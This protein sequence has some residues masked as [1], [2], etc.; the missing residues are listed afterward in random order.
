MRLLWSKPGHGK[1]FTGEMML[2]EDYKS[3]HPFRLPGAL[4]S[5]WQ[6]NLTLARSRTSPVTLRKPV[7]FW[8]R[9]QAEHDTA[10]GAANQPVVHHPAKAPSPLRFAGALQEGVGSRRFFQNRSNRANVD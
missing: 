2:F 8:M 10:L 4:Q 1:S 7:R 9:W 5:L 3:S 6:F